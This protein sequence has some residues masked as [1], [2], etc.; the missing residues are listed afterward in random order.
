M[1][2]NLSITSRK[3]PGDLFSRR[4]TLRLLGTA[5]AATLVDWSGKPLLSALPSGQIHKPAVPDLL[6]QS[7]FSSAPLRPTRAVETMAC[8]SRPALTEGPFFEDELL[9]RSDIR[10][11]PGTGGVSA[12]VPLTLTLNIFSTS[13]S[14]CIPLSGA[15]VD[16]WHC[17]AAGNYSDE[18]AGAGNGNT[19]GLKNLRGYQLTDSNGSV[20]F[21]TIYPGWYSGR[22]VHIHYKVR[23]FAGATRTYDF[24]SQ[25]FFDDTLTDQVYTQAPYNSRGTRNTR[26][27]NDGIYQSGG[28]ALILSLAPDGRGGYTSTW[29]IGLTGLPAS[30]AA[31]ATTV[32]A[33]SYANAAASEGIVALFGTGLATNT[34]GATTLPLPTTLDGVQVMVRDALGTTR[35]APLFFVSPGQINFQIPPGTTAGSA[36]IYAL[37][38]S[39]AVGQGDVTI[40][41]VVPSLF[42]ANAD[43]QGVPAGYAI[44]QKQDNSQTLR[45]IAQLNGT[46]GKFEAIPIDLG[47]ANDQVFLVLFGTGFRYRSILSAATCTIGGTSAEVLYAGTQ[48]GFAGLDQANIL[49][50][51]SLAGRGSVDLHFVVDGMA[52]NT[53]ALNIA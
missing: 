27:S 12:G 6:R 19:L 46:S 44:L 33:A 48:N 9:F 51:H 53:L 21:T 31:S 1:R 35:A 5:G 38:N 10:T 25:L 52:A 34:T 47:S 24:T 8:V 13:G 29:D 22:T 42:A 39:S 43:G 17:D 28:S 32:S 41:T 18:P 49:I 16:I 40:A 4:E 37:R 26:N 15:I 30:V 14:D 11:D 7:L 2:R 50:P 23:L 20:T 3:L 36:F 45:A